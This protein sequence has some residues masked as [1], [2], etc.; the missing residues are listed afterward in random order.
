MFL[1]L[2]QPIGFALIQLATGNPLIDPLLLVGLALV[3]YRSVCLGVGQTRGQDDCTDGKQDLIH[4]ILLIWITCELQ[5][6]TT[7]APTVR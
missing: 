6:A 2:V 7:R 4:H 5:P 3:D 1:L